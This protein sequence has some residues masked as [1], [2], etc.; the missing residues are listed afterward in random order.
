LQDFAKMARRLS[1]RLFGDK[2]KEAKVAEPKTEEVAE[3]AAPAA[4]EETKVSTRFLGIILLR[5]LPVLQPHY[6]LPTY[7][8][9]RIKVADGDPTFSALVSD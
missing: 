1:G 5:R 4:A 6:L 7:I 2:K 3:E 9:R 8:L